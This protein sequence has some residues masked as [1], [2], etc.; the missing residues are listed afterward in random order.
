MKKQIIDKNQ[1][2]ELENDV[3]SILSE[4]E[5]DIIKKRFGIGLNKETL[6][7]IGKKY[8]V[9]RERVRQ[10]ESVIIKKIASI[11]KQN[12]KLSSLKKEILNLIE[13][14][15]GIVEENFL[16][17]NFF[18]GLNKEEKDITKFI[19]NKLFDDYL[20]IFKD[21][22]TKSIIYKSK[23]LNL[24]SFNIIKN[25]I[26]GIINN[27]KEPLSFEEIID[28]LN[29]SGVFKKTEEILSN[30][31]KKSKTDNFKL[32]QNTIY[33]ALHV[34]N[35]TDLNIFQKWGMKNWKTIKPKR[36]SDKI[37]LVLN[38]EGKPTHF[39]KITDIINEYNFDS[40]KAKDVTV[41][42]E[43][44]MD[45]RYILV[46]RGIYALKE[47]GYKNGAVSDIIEDLLKN[48]KNILSKKE[49]IE[50]VK[51]Q[52]LV[53]DSTIYLA[54]TNNPKFKKVKEGYKLA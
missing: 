18:V 25:D 40:K 48:S 51:E 21:K 4:Q 39:K 12:S 54:L 42:N 43:L 52:R 27:V 38:K 34:M 24:E 41:H 26:E 37:Y 14:Y 53:K 8:G 31:Y 36:M 2:S 28:K 15:G 33:S 46:G 29:L 19:L 11:Q 17:D 50:K 9:T 10:I 3:F 20:D 7:E 22:K 45:P 49:I 44:I 30:L 32:F 5:I 16:L 47:W 6:E 1:I 13:E 35:N 23:N